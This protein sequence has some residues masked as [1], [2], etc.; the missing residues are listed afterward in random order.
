MKKPKKDRERIYE[1]TKRR[2]YRLMD[3]HFPKV[4]VFDG[5]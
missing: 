4:I 2:A 1:Q 5:C 3:G